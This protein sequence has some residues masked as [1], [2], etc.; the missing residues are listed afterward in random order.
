MKIR[1]INE[2]LAK[3]SDVRVEAVSPFEKEFK[4]CC[5]LIEAGGQNHQ[6][7]QNDLIVLALL[8]QCPKSIRQYLHNIIFFKRKTIPLIVDDVKHIGIFTEVV[9]LT[10]KKS[11]KILEK[12][13]AVSLKFD[14]RDLDDENIKCFKGLFQLADRIDL[15]YCS[16]FHSHNC[17]KLLDVILE[18]SKHYS[19]I[20]LSY[21]VTGYHEGDRIDKFDW[22]PKVGNQLKELDVKVI[23]LKGVLLPCNASNSKL[24]F[25][26]VE[27]ALK[28]KKLS[29]LDVRA[30]NFQHFYPGDWT[31]RFP[32]LIKISSLEQLLFD[33]Y[34]D[35][36]EKLITELLLAKNTRYGSPGLFDGKVTDSISMSG[37]RTACNF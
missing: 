36:D 29:V 34:S 20:N 2:I 35:I 37:S 14:I 16:L 19:E 10:I 23:R 28:N 13:I 1:D 18:A 32:E 25:Y 30:N 24:M 8:C 21:N 7:A 17:V 6:S 12:E 11:A 31:E 9:M 5:A 27:A 22:F 3:I 15:A 26:L 4:K 33:R